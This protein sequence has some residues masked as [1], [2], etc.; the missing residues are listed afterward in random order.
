M[1]RILIIRR[2]GRAKDQLCRA[3]LDAGFEPVLASDGAQALAKLHE[4]DPDVVIMSEE[5]KL[6]E[7]VELCRQLR[8][9]TDVPIVVLDGGDNEV[10]GPMMLER[11]ADAYL[12]KSTS[13]VVLIARVRSLLRRSAP[14]DRIG[15]PPS[16]NDG[17]PDEERSVTPLE[18][19]LLSCLLHSR[20]HVVPYPRL[21]NEIWGG[22][23]ASRDSLHFHMRRLQN[24]LGGNHLTQVRG[25][26]YRITASA[27]GFRYGTA[28]AGNV[29]STSRMRIEPSGPGR[30]GVFTQ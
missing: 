13:S 18:S 6:L 11:G 4:T 21:I 12:T 3:L 20:D 24:K 17:G 14:S 25:V 23:R 27:D 29:V 15:N 9:A 30:K 28:S 8:Q 26:G 19:R 10:A 1:K 5:R 2:Q 7:E 16:P 22:N